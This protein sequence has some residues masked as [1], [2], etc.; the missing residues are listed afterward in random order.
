MAL[1]RLLE[2]HLHWVGM[3]TRWDYSEPTWQLNRQTILA[4]YPCP[5]HLADHW[6][7]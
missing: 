7:R 4:G 1:Q 3:L 6:T 2:E 5:L